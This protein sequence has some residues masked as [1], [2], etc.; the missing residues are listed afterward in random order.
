VYLLFECYE[1]ECSWSDFREEE[2]DV[3]FHRSQ[4]PPTEQEDGTYRKA[5]RTHDAHTHNAPMV[6]CMKSK[7]RIEIRTR[8]RI[9]RKRRMRR[10]VRMERRREINKSVNKC[11]RLNKEVEKKG[12][13]EGRGE[14]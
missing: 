12:E 6:I 11:R 14:E 9:R 4:Y 2:I 1:H 7:M 3:R 8:M 5:Y 13:D 10:R